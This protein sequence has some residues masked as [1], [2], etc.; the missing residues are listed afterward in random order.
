[1]KR[2]E[3]IAFLGGITAAWPIAARAQRSAMPV[4]G[5][6]GS[7]SPGPY[8][9]SVT[10]FRQGLNETGFSEGRN[11]AIEYRWAEGQYERMARGRI[12]VATPFFTERAVPVDAI[13]K[14]KLLVRNAL[15][16]RAWF[17]RQGPAWPN[18]CRCQRTNTK[19]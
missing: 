15:R 4:I 12:L 6:L 8:A 18:F 16:A 14:L 10:A 13:P 7:G 9:S 17:S 2:R 3:F 19:R 5:F 1:M 11:V